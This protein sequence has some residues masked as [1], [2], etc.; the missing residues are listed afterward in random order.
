[1]ANDMTN[2]PWIFD[3]ADAEAALKSLPRNVKRVN[4]VSPASAGDV[5]LIKDA[6]GAVVVNAVCEVDGQ[7]QVFLVEHS[8]D[9]LNVERI[10]SGTAY[11]H[12]N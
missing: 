2:N 6:T 8:Y 9:G 3:T 1:M 7:S 11:V 10:D 5:L 4:W 12:F